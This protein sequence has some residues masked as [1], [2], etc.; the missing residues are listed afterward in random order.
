MSLS[1][2]YYCIYDSLCG[3]RNFKPT[4]CLFLPF[5]LSYVTVLRPYRLSELPLTG[6]GTRLF[7]GYKGKNRL[8]S[9]PSPR[10]F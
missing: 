1:I 8:F 10:D 6:Q 3:C 2:F 9:S 7:K 4:L 5:L